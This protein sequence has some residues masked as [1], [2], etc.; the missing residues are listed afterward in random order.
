MRTSAILGAAVVLAATGITGCTSSLQ[1][2]LVGTTWELEAIESMDDAQ[3]TT[4]I[5]DPGKFSLTFDKANKAHFNFDCNW[6][7][8]T[9]QTKPSGDG[10]TGNLTFGPIT[11]SNDRCAQPALSETVI[12]SMSQIR[13][14]VYK[15]GQLSLSKEADGGIL[16]YRP[17]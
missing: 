2:P 11:T 13:S 3:G 5:P 10:S 9:Y 12:S 4:K 1:T 8:G 15:D 14:Y 16:H 17:A 7:K 6:G